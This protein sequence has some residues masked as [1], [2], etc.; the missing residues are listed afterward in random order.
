MEMRDAVATGERAA[1]IL[2]AVGD[3][4]ALAGTLG[5]LAEALVSVGDFDAAAKVEQEVAPLAERLGNVG[6]TWHS[7]MVQ[8]ALTFCRSG[9]LD[10][11][12]AIARRE[13]DLCEEAGMGWASWG[14]SWLSLVELLRGHGAAA[15]AHGEKA[16]ALAAPTTM[17][18][19]EWAMH[20]ESRAWAGQRDEAL[21]LFERGRADLPRV[22]EPAGWGPWIMLVSAV[23]GLVALG[24]RQ[25]AAALYPAVLHCLDRTGVVDA[26]PNDCKLVE[27]VAG[28]AAAA[29]SNWDAAE[30]HYTTALRQAAELPHLPEQAGTRRCYAAMLLERNAPGDEQQAEQ[31]LAEADDLARRLRFSPRDVPRGSRSL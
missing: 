9:D 29:G 8:G 21:A 4:W 13:I 2:R 22:G 20:F 14:W 19:L 1:G 28:L 11:L 12:E 7:V 5:F 31:L 6:A 27:R 25:E 16:E 15:I 24:E 3:L 30:A 10:G 18:G 23:E 17:R 26:Y